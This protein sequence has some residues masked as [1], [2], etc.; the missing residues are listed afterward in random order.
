MGS[1][2][3]L[4]PLL[5]ILGLSVAYYLYYL[6]KKNPGGEG[7]VAEIAAAIH[8]GA[9]VFIRREYSVLAIF[10]AVVA[11]LLV[12]SPLGVATAG[13]FV[14]G[15]LCSAAAGLIGMSTATRANVRTTVAAHNKGAEAALSV[16]FFGGSIMGRTQRLRT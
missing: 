6:V 16:A 11:I 3:A 13:A 12:V 14:L 5:G 10:V 7:K 2:H 8:S 15:A 1:L 9:L 4:P